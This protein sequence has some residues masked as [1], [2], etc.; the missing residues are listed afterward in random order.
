MDSEGWD[1]HTLRDS[2][3]DAVIHVRTA[4][5]GAEDFYG[6]DNK[7]RYENLEM[8]RVTCDKTF[9]AYVGHRAHYVIDNLGEPKGFKT[10]LNRFLNCIKMIVGLGN[11]NEFS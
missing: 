2:R 9:Q 11:L 7:A 5:Y 6:H 1:S 4:A 8:A 3:Y 10:K